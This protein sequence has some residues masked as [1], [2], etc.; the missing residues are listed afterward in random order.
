[1]TIRPPVGLTFVAVLLFW[2]VLSVV[3]LICGVFWLAADLLATA[4]AGWLP[5]RAVD[6][7]DR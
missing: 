7:A 2:I 3:A 1:M 6:Q 5:S 4:V